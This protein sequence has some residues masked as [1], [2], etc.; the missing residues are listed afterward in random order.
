VNPHKSR[1][2]RVVVLGDITLDILAPI[3]AL[4]NAGED[5]LSPRL[6]LHCGGVAA[7]CAVSLA[8]W[9]VPVRLLG[10]VGHDGFADIVLR[11]LR[12]QGVDVSQVQRTKKALTGIMYIAVTPD[13]ERTFFGSRGAG[14]VVQPRKEAVWLRSVRAAHFAGYN[15]L[16]PSTAKT[17]EY[18]LNSIRKVGGTT[19]LDV[20]SAPSL[21]VPGKIL[22]VSRKVDIL[23]V[24]VDEA[25]AIT[26]TRTEQAAFDALRRAG[27]REVVL[28]LGER[29]C[30]I[31]E[32]GKLRQIPAFSV[33]V[34][35]T[36]GAGDA[37]VAAY[38]QARW[39]GWSVMEAALVA[40]AAGAAAA[41]V[42]GAGERMPRVRDILRLIRRARLG[43]DWDPIRQQVV[44]RL[45][46]E[47]RES[48]PNSRGGSSAS[49]A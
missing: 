45:S 19:S 44:M 31:F 35:D 48:R 41:S 40:N 47:L 14:E 13:G 2:G 42:V 3:Q 34:I 16:S 36:T 30:L 17:A 7:N 18:L 20:G 32:S 49:Q 25:R 46:R 10:A 9:G 11:I 12:T 24:S 21:E 22:Q 23:F 4:P 28:K 37:F 26:G 29:G 8:R 43:Q 15:F 5:C 1:P 39:R 33:S 38:L 27:A 6:E